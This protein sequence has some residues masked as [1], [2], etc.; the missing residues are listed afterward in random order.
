MFISC[1]KTISL[2][3]NKQNLQYFTNVFKF[4]ICSKLWK[5]KCG[6]FDFLL[7]SQQ[8]LTKSPTVHC[9]YVQIHIH[10]FIHWNHSWIQF[11][12]PHTLTHSYRSLTHSPF[13]VVAIPRDVLLF[14]FWAPWCH[15]YLKFSCDASFHFG[16]I[17]AIAD[18]VVDV[19]GVW[20]LVAVDDLN[21]VVYVY[22]VRVVA[23]TD[24]VVD[25]SSDRLMF[26]VWKPKNKFLLY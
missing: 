3:I 17:Y 2:N 10:S 6:F 8:F 25:V 20:I 14:A 24:G 11:T 12:R 15:N 22:S 5:G 26:A 18:A 4:S 23:A 16:T 13:H 9:S 21:A 19:V 1:I 7:S